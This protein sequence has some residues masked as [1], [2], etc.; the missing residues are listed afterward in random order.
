MTNVV[1]V[2]LDCVRSD[3]L[4][5]YGNEEVYTPTIDDLADRG[6]VFDQHVTAAPWT[7]PSVTSMLTGIY[8]HNLRMFRFREKFPD[9]VTTI[10]HYLE[11]AGY[12][13]GTYT[14]SEGWFGENDFVNEKGLTRNIESVRS[15]IESWAGEDFFLFAHYWNTH[16]PYFDKYSREAWY[17]TRDDI[18]DLIRRDDAESINK[19]KN[20][21]RSAIERASEEF[22]YALVEKLKSEGI[23]K[24]TYLVITGD[25]G[26]SWGRRLD[27]RSDLTVF[28]MHGKHLYEEVLKVPLVLTGPDIPEG[29]KVAPTT[30]SIDV[31]PTILDL[32]DIE[33][34]DMDGK[35]LRPLI[36]GEDTESRPIVAATTYVDDPDGD[37]DEVISKMAYRTDQWKLICNLQDDRY[38]EDRYELYNLHQDPDEQR[39][40]VAD[41]PEVF[42][43][44]K[45]RIEEVRADSA[46]TADEDVVRSRLEELGYL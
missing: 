34:E 18:I 38:S 10:Y 1:W 33:G 40:V 6:V 24:D 11:D 45:T 41:N 5:C 3:F 44:L 14:V 20:L 12:E 32:L 8:P 25:H 15:T 17:D 30:R 9:D 29:T 39:N 27:D 21:Y 13:V 22:V 37:V 16:L 23:F 31:L 43:E 2:V 26:E 42:E 19:A 36:R 4:G 35:T 28:G 46:G 7:N